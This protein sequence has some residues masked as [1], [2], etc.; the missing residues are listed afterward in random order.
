MA[1]AQGRHEKRRQAETAYLSAVAAAAGQGSPDHWKALE[2]ALNE[3]R[4]EPAGYD[5]DG[6]AAYFGKP[7]AEIEAALA[8][9][10][11]PPKITQVKK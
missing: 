2:R 11:I 10:W 8:R 6:L 5:V 9:G 4:D 3:A 1:D 7:R